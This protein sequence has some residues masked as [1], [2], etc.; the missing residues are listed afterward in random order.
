MLNI[1]GK[2]SRGFCMAAKMQFAGRERK[3]Y[4]HPVQRIDAET[5]R[6]S[7]KRRGELKR[8]YPHL[9]QRFFRV[10]C[11][12]SVSPVGRDLSTRGARLLLDHYP[13]FTRTGNG[14]HETT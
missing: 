6:K 5:A 11:V 12:V 8:V 9:L 1:C 13:S 2:L 4:K 10:L 14:T 3:R 7:R